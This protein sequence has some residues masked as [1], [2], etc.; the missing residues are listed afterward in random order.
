MMV[1]QN[2]AT[3]TI[4]CLT[5]SGPGRYGLALCTGES[6]QALWLFEDVK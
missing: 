5:G 2:T 1:L 6:D 4:L 3:G